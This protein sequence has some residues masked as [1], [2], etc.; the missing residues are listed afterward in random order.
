[1]TQPRAPQPTTYAI[2][3]GVWTD[4]PEA[5]P[6]ARARVMDGYGTAQV[7]VSLAGELEYDENAGVVIDRYEDPKYEDIR[8]EAR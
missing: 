4:M 1:M 2:G 8:N 3:S 5:R 7:T 6:R